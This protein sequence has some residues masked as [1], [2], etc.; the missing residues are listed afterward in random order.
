MM[1]LNMGNWEIWQLDHK[2]V[3][4]GSQRLAI[5]SAGVASIDIKTD[6][7]SDW[8]E[9]ARLQSNLRFTPAIRAIGGDPTSGGQTAGDI[10]FMRNNWRIVIDLAKTRLTGV[11][12]S[13]D[14][15][16]PL[17]GVNGEAV[18]QS[19]VSSLVTGVQIPVVT[20]DLATTDAKIDVLAIDVADLTVDVSGVSTEVT[21]LHEASYNRR[22]HDSTA[23]TIT[24]Y[25][26]DNVTPK[27]VFDTN[28]DLSDI[29]PQ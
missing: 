18:F 10:Y 3:F 23:D 25:E 26:S 5:V 21:E 22:V 15:D 4:D 8:K 28:T 12:F 20:G 13:D 14:Y 1:S 6:L 29:T 17:L 24:I 11:V 7:Y 2:I 27:K 16:S 19:V 9:W